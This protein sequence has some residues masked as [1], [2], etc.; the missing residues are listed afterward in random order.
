MDAA[1]YG[2][3]DLTAELLYEMLRFRQA[4]FVVEQ[5]SPYPDLDDLDQRAAHLLLRIEGALAGT[6]RLVPFADQNRIA[7]G[8][9]AVVAKRRRQGLARHLMAMA[10]IRCERDYPIFTVTLSAQTYLASFYETLG[11]RTIKEPYDDYGVPHV[12]M[13]RFSS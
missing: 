11:F 4:V 5:R 10:L 8:R 3:G 1:W 6:L 7:I 12:E 2:F 13:K 9:V